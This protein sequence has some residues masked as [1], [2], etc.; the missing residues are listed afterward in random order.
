MTKKSLLELLRASDDPID[1]SAYEELIRRNQLIKDMREVI[2]REVPIGKIEAGDPGLRTRV[3]LTE[4]EWS[5]SD[6]FIESDFR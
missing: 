5:G 6:F 1:R 4:P 3:Q 2:Y